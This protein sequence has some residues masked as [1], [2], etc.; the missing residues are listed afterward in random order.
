MVYY[1]N[2]NGGVLSTAI[3]NVLSG[4]INSVF[5]AVVAWNDRRTTR[6]ALSNLSDRAL[7]D[8]GISRAD[9]NEITRG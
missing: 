4:A 7:D 8:I 2:A 1:T 6:I 5:D 3:A 9:I